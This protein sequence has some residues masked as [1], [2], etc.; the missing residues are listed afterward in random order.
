MLHARLQGNK[1]G[2]FDIVFDSTA[3][4][5][6]EAGQSKTAE[7]GVAYYDVWTSFSIANA[8]RKEAVEKDISQTLPAETGAR[9]DPIV[10][11]S[12]VIDAHIMPP[13][14]LDADVT[15]ELDVKR[16]GSRFLAFELSRFLQ[17]KSV[18]ADGT[19]VEFI[20]NPAVEGTRLARSGNDLLAVI[21]PKPAVE[22]Q[23]IKLHFIYGG[24][25]IAEAGK[26]LLYVGERGTWYPNRGMNMTDFDLTFHY[27]PGWT[28]LATG[29]PVEQRLQL[30]PSSQATSQ[31]ASGEQVTRW[32]SER[33]IPVAGFN[34]GK[35]IRG[36][37]QTGNVIVEAYATPGLEREFPQAPPQL[38]QIEPSPLHR[39]PTSQIPP[40]QITPT[41]PSPARNA[42]AVAETAAQAIHS[43]AE[44]FG[45]YP[46]SQ[47]A[48][49][50]LPGRESQGWPGLI[51]L[52]SYAFLTRQEQS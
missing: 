38:I 13:K 31:N 1:L 14:E 4:E 18:E 42:S 9:E 5:Q 26:G 49:T 39:T 19:A 15:L 23:K 11:R 8:G 22:K 33:P 50:Q 12:Y 25:V 7:N 47:L 30:P 44:R 34:L 48:L 52:S 40:A 10:V 37:A 36:T 41:P 3:G 24:E 29:K 2:V 32:L 6:V 28:L 43:Y 20:H 21:L 16:G 17:V 46:Y 45:P 35:Y 51:F 27:P